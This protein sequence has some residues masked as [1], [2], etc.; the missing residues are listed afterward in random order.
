MTLGLPQLRPPSSLSWQLQRPYIVD[1]RG[2]H[3]TGN[4]YLVL[5]HEGG[6]LVSL[7]PFHAIGFQFR[8]VLPVG[9]VPDVIPV[10]TRVSRPSTHDPHAI[11]VSHRGEPYPLVPASPGGFL[12][13]VY[14][15]GAAPHV[16]IPP[17][18]GVI[19]PPTHDIHAIV[20]YHCLVVCPGG[21]PAS[22]VASFQFF[23]SSEYHTSFSKDSLSP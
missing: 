2:G 10:L 21:Q 1:K 19:V 20:Q 6:M 13:P 18:L 3:T 22:A 15:V 14:P 12:S 11:P 5:E 16:V 17:V 23:P 4:P 9:R 7:F 8:P